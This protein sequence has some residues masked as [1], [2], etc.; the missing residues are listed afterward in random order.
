MALIRPIAGGSNVTLTPYNGHGSGIVQGTFTY[1]ADQAQDVTMMLEASVFAAPLHVDHNS[2]EIGTI[3][4]TGDN[5]IFRT[6]SSIHLDANDT[7]TVTGNAEWWTQI[8]STGTGVYTNQA[9]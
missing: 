8:T 7:I 4:D 9:T 3:S 1:T 2:T 6:N 5:K